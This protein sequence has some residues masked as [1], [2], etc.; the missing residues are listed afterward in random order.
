M[1]QVA[2]SSEIRD[3]FVKPVSLVL[4]PFAELWNPKFPTG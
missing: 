4:P 3:I 1:I 2:T